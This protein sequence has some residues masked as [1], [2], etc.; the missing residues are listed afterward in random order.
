MDT[1]LDNFKKEFLQFMNDELN[2][3]QSHDG[4]WLPSWSEK[5]CHRLQHIEDQNWE[6]LFIIFLKASGCPLL[7]IECLIGLSFNLIQQTSFVLIL[8]Y[9]LNMVR[10]TQLLRK[11]C[12]SKDG[13]N[14][15]QIDYNFVIN[16]L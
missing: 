8:G 7:E 1:R 4:W 11:H 10:I 16:N 14:H 6:S 9:S 5:A 3:K 13:L 15:L 12:C 2:N